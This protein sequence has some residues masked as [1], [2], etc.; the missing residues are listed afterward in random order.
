MR[1]FGL[2]ADPH[3]QSRPLTQV[4]THT[5]LPTQSLS[6]L[7]RANAI[8]RRHT[9]D[10]ATHLISRSSSSHKPSENPSAVITNF[11]A[12]V[13]FFHE[14][15]YRLPGKGVREDATKEDVDLI[16]GGDEKKTTE[17]TTPSIV[18][19]SHFVS[20]RN[21]SL[22]RRGVTQKA[23]HAA[24]PR[25]SEVDQSRTP[26]AFSPRISP[27][28]RGD[29]SGLSQRHALNTSPPDHVL[30][31]LLPVCDIC[32]CPASANGNDLS[33]FLRSLFQPE[34]SSTD[35]HPAPIHSTLC[36][37][38]PVCDSCFA[39][40]IPVRIASDFWFDL[41]RE[42][43]AR[44]PSLSCN[45]RDKFSL[46]DTLSVTTPPGIFSHVERYARAMAY[47]DALQELTPSP[48]ESAL[49]R[50]AELHE[51]L[52]LHGRMKD[53]MNPREPLRTEIK[54][55]P[56]DSADG[57]RTLQVPIFVDLI[58]PDQAGS[59]HCIVCIET[60]PDVTD[61][62]QEGGAS[63]AKDT[64]GFPGDWNYLIRSFMS[65]SSLP[66]CSATHD[67]DICRNCLSHH[68]ESQLESR[69]RGGVESLAC[70]RLRCSHI[71][72][73]EEVRKILNPEAFARYD[74]LRLLSSLATLPNFRWCLREGCEFGQEHDFPTPALPSF[75]AD[76]NLSQQNRVVCDECGFAMCFTHQTPWHEGVDCI[77]FGYSGETLAAS[78]AW[79]RRNTK[80]CP[81]CHTPLERSDGC[82][83]MTCS[84][85][86]YEFCWL[87]LADWRGV[88]E[89][90]PV[91]HVTS[92]WRTGH[93]V[94]CYFRRDDA[95]SAFM[96]QGATLE[97]ALRWEVDWW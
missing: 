67:L 17:T 23:E 38:T 91:T 83:H 70:P 85:C 31:T 55:L 72:T 45:S 25:G 94:G 18:S 61:R 21:I 43:W 71:Y 6:S 20:P 77:E 69:G 51:R 1:P 66:S 19:S 46:G 89:E 37:S 59:R 39:I 8:T 96:I 49:R 57:S 9:T 97:E 76:L 35:F 90:N 63:W 28:P 54:V 12:S 82:F 30:G 80:G 88:F 58:V 56:V 3:P 32:H 47:R 78:Q 26:Y 40:A 75:P 74:K 33:S 14:E 41:D 4:V 22:D 42:C 7:N 79:L 64:L 87:C 68:I 92:Y 93:A 73:H 95:P 44:C 48:A 62:T 2:P 15:I 27:P 16:N 11:L 24:L 86:R 65:P 13:E 29:G 10:K 81:R 84:L 52:M 5:T 36:C 34:S 60:L 50:A 53:P